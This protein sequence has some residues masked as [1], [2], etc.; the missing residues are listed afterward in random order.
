MSA[1]HSQVGYVKKKKIKLVLNKYKGEEMKSDSTYSGNI[2]DPK[3]ESSSSSIVKPL[4]FTCSET[5]GWGWVGRVARGGGREKLPVTDP[6]PPII[7]GRHAGVPVAKASFVQ[8][9]F[10]SHLSVST[11]RSRHAGSKLLS[12]RSGR[13]SELDWPGHTAVL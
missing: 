6:P 11:K 3:W 13:S 2:A 4:Q 9:K 5:G 1:T 8:I 12:M 10:T 7:K